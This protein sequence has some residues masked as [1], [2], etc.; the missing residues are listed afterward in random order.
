MSRSMFASF[1]EARTAV[2]TDRLLVAAERLRHALETRYD[3]SQPRHPAGTSEGGR[4]RSSSSGKVMSSNVASETVDRES[5]ANPALADS[6]A[7]SAEQAFI[8]RQ[9]RPPRPEIAEN[10]N[11]LNLASG[12]SIKNIYGKEILI[13]I[14]FPHE[15]VERSIQSI[16]TNSMNA[17]VSYL[18]LAEFTMGLC[19]LEIGG[20]W[21]AQRL[22]GHYVDEYRDYA[23]VMIGYYGGSVGVPESLMLEVQNTYARFNSK[24]SKY[25]PMD[26]IYRFLPRGNVYNTKIGYYLAT[27]Q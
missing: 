13:P 3:P 1:P 7:D 17:D 19:R 11:I 15:A 14:D 22:T 8:L 26:D 10:S 20:E 9:V 6:H 16:K 2:A 23:T 5:P 24:F 21:D 18:G 12:E 27:Q 4:W 25:E